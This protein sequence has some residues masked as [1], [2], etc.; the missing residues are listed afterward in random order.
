M[1]DTVSKFDENSSKWFPHNG[2]W[3]IPPS[4]FSTSIN[5][6]KCH[7]HVLSKYVFVSFTRLDFSL[8]EFHSLIRFVLVL[9]RFGFFDVFLPIYVY[10]ILHYKYAHYAH[11]GRPSLRCCPCTETRTTHIYFPFL[12][13]FRVFS[14]THRALYALHSLGWF[15]GPS[16]DDEK[17]VDIGC[18]RKRT[19]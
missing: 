8:F 9:F 18:G 14:N 17:S 4:K 15:N 2:R 6:A 11:I 7:F 16:F 5:F 12:F 1:R 3:H 19:K 13:Y 10:T